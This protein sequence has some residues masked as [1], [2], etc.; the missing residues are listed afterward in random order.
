[1]DLLRADGRYVA[2]APKPAGAL[3][4]KTRIEA[5]RHANPLTFLP[6]NIP[7]TRRVRTPS[8]RSRRALWL[9][10]AD[11]NHFKPYNDYYRLL[12][13]ATRTIGLPVSPWSN[14]IPSGITW[15][16]WGA[17]TLFCCSRAPI[18][19]NAANV[20]WPSLPS[21]PA[22]WFDDA[23]GRG[24]SKPRTGTGYD[25]F[26]PVPL[27]R[28][29]LRGGRSRTFHPCGLRG[30]SWPP[31]AELRGQT[32]H[33]RFTRNSAGLD[34]ADV[35]SPWRFCHASSSSATGG[36]SCGRQRSPKPYGNSNAPRRLPAGPVC[37]GHAL[38][39]RVVA[40]RRITAKRRQISC[41]TKSSW[42]STGLSLRSLPR[43]PST[44]RLRRCISD[45]EK[46]AAS[47]LSRM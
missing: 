14:V 21:G 41:S 1:M 8:R 23:C 37:Q 2:W 7:I 47:A 10:Y 6:G 42:V 3:G 13:G 28:S 33:Y 12:G 5:A 46:P 45:S 22:P 16:T 4:N 43:C 29:V 34:S 36:H 35:Q 30:E 25:G 11:L 18:G 44:S 39:V 40:W 38:E 26:S 24:H 31:I 19:V 27:C 9:C 20:W 17:M 15:G 32:V